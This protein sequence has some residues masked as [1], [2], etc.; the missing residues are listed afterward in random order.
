MFKI[1]GRILVILL[2]AAIVA[3]GLYALIQN[4][5]TN[6]IAFAPGRQF[7]SGDT[8]G[9]S[10]S[11]DQFS[12]RDGGGRFSLGRGMGGVWLT[13]L[14]IGAI[15]LIVIQVQKVLAKSPRQTISGPT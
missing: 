11:R 12:E 7:Q 8:H 10:V 2:V 1:I 4:G 9:T 5:I 3:G 14:E 15:T 6:S 13:L